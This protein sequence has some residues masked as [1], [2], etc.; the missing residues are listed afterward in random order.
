MKFSECCLR[1]AGGPV[2]KAALRSHRD[3]F[4][5]VGSLSLRKAPMPVTGDG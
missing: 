5:R 4:G 3:G 1:T 2:E